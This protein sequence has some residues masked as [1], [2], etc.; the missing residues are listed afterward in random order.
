M[1][2]LTE[3]VSVARE[4]DSRNPDGGLAGFLEQVSLVADADEIPEGSDRGG[5]VTLMTLH[6]AKGAG[7]PR[8]VPDRDGGGRLPPRA[9]DRRRPVSSR[10]SAGSSTSA[11]PGRGEEALPHLGGG[12]GLVGPLSYHK[13]SRFLTEIPAELIDWRRDASAAAS[14]LSPRPPSDWPAVLG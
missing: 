7:V 6:T 1:E 2:N 12:P 10:R 9:L 3:L 11:S 13:Q 14:M 5:L 8:G 4:F